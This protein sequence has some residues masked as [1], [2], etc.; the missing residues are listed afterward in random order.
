MSRRLLSV[1]WCAALMILA[2]AGCNDAASTT[3][4]PVA[5]L[6]PLGV[7]TKW[8]YDRVDSVEFPII[9]TVPTSRTTRTVTVTRLTSDASGNSWAVLDSANYLLDGPINGPTYLANL[10]GG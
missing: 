7:G 6:F 5:T 10:D 8:V 2:V 4:S 1:A 3:P 9:S